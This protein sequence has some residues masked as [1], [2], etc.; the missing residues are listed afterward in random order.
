V[1][2][3]H[4]QGHGFA[5]RRP[6]SDDRGRLPRLR[7]QCGESLGLV[8]LLGGGAQQRDLPEPR[9]AAG[10]GISQGD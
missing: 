2:G 4:R 9:D 6:R 1:A 7:L 3:R 5:R 8:R 10:G